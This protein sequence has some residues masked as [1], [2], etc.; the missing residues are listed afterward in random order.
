MAGKALTTLEYALLGLV[1]RSPMSGYDIKRV[2]DSTP[3]AHFSSSPG[4]IYPALKRLAKRGLLEAELDSTT[5]ARPRRV[6]SLTDEGK[7]ALGEWLREGVTI[8]EF[9]RDGRA[10]LLRFSL[11]EGHLTTDEVIAYLEQLKGVIS[12]YLEELYAWRDELGTTGSLH[13]RLSLENGI[14]GYRQLAEWV[15]F[16]L[17]EIRANG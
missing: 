5:E 14:Q 3:L 12:S 13:Q 15:D 11:A 8:D 1:D 7:A 16:A 10:P 17:G 6:F 9:V 4:A 2:F